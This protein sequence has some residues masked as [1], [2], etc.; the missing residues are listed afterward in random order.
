MKQVLPCSG[1]RRTPGSQR[2][3][4]F[5]RFVSFPRLVL[6]ALLCLAATPY[7]GEALAAGTMTAMVVAG[8]TLQAQ[9]LPIPAPGPGEVRIRVRAAGVNPVDWKLAARAPA[10]SRQVPG[11]DV[12][13]IVDAVGSD[14]GPWKVGEAVVA[15]ASGGYAQYALANAAAVAAKP[16]GL[17]FEQAAGIPVV[18]ETAWRAMVTVAD[19]RPGQ[20]VLV[21]GGAGGVGSA[22]VQIAKSRG[23]YVIATASPSHDRLLHSLGADQII[24]YNTVRFEDRV[25]AVDVV[26]NT[27]NPGIGLRSIG[28]IRPG[29]VLVSVVGAP[30]ADACARAGIRCEQ[31]GHVSGAYLGAVLQLAAA[32]KFRVAI[33]RKLP[34]ADAARAWQLSRAGHVGGKIVLMVP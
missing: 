2:R 18:G 7:G 17:S 20:H 34:L 14:A 26:L 23:A 24:D 5:P 8:G 16:P 13:G 9:S 1:S 6:A 11:K 10:G 21:Q 33:D 3:V 29:G 32:G 31:T 30:P 15:L 25:H 22:A 19:V 4:A 28:V 27:V 12:A